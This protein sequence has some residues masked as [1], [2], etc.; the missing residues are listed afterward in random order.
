MS[1]WWDKNPFSNNLSKTRFIFN[2]VALFM[3]HICFIT[4]TWVM[5]SSFI[6]FNLNKN[7][8]SLLDRWSQKLF[9][10]KVNQ[11]LPN[12]EFGAS[13]VPTFTLFIS[14]HLLSSRGGKRQSTNRV[15]K[16]KHVYFRRDFQ[17]SCS[18]VIYGR[19]LLCLYCSC[20]M[21]ST[22]YT[23]SRSLSLWLSRSS[24]WLWHLRVLQ[25]SRTRSVCQ[26]PQL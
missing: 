10:R 25:I 5:S 17:T 3:K 6:I 15:G 21:T 12:N 9:E 7:S 20:V 13:F 24:V 18:I 4:V 23:F 26:M 11:Y 1:S 16:C 2:G 22:H 8:V 14:G 19:S